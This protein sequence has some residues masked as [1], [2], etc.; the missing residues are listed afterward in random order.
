[1]N[2]LQSI[3]GAGKKLF[4]VLLLGLGAAACGGGSSGSA[5]ISSDVGGDACVPGTAAASSNCGSVYVAL[6]DAEGDFTSYTVDVL[7]I[8]LERAS[9]ARVETLPASTRIDFAQLTDLWELVSVATL[10]PGDIVGGR[11]R[12]DYGDAEIFVESDGDIVPAE[13][14]GADGMPLG[15]VDVDVQLAE[16]DRLVVTRGRAA[17]LSIDFDLAAS[18]TVDTSA[19]PAR[20]VAAPYL[21]A[22]IAPVDQKELRI[23]GALA[24]VDVAAGTYDVRVRPWHDRFGDHGGLT[25]HTTDATEFEID[26][27]SYVG[28]AGLEALSAEPAGTLTV[29]FGTLDIASRTFTAAVVHAGGSLGGIRYSAV[30][31]NIVSRTDGQLVLKGVVAVRRDRRAHFHRTVIVDVGPET[32]V[33]RIGSPGVMLDERDLSV[34]Q[35]IAAFGELRNPEVD[36]SDPFGPDT[37][38]LLDATNGRVRMLVTRLHGRVTGFVPGQVNMELRAID[39]LGIEMFSFAGTGRDATLDAD[40]SDYEIATGSLPLDAIAVDRPARV[41]GFVTR[42]GEAPPDFEG[43]TIVGYRDIPAALGIGWTLSGTS[44][45]FSSMGPDSLVLDLA[46]PDIGLRHHMLLGPELVDLFDLPASPAIGPNPVRGLY[47]IWEPGHVELFGDFT[48]FVD[49][50]A[51][52]LGGTDRARSLSAYGHY[53]ESGNVLTAGHISVHMLPAD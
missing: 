36:D 2:I 47:G 10:A 25:V 48:E 22:E 3:A 12:I 18:H 13:I 45:P 30:Y 46:N 28:G 14:V 43:R 7:S 24:D 4:P 27:M 31:G 42:F 20:V 38:L 53:D 50:L 15:I 40:P 23:R 44:A 39:R 35:R 26:E 16:R 34:G 11:I 51:L 37:G 8:S 1:M 6:T 49:E 41:L 19:S 32:G 33:S 29:A 9:G 52:R 5:R 21:V 17:F